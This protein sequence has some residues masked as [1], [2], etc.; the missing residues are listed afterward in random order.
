MRKKRYGKLSTTATAREAKQKRNGDIYRDYLG[1][2]KEGNNISDIY[3]ELAK[4]YGVSYRTIQNVVTEER[5]KAGRTY[6]DD[7]KIAGR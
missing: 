7:F 4:Q 3:F 5:K 6:L 2:L 1:F